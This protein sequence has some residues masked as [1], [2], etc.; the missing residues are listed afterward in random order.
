M[1][2]KC[3][4][5]EALA[6]N[7]IFITVSDVEVK[8]WNYLGKELTELE[9]PSEKRYS[10]LDSTGQFIFLA[11]TQTIISLHLKKENDH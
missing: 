2:F 4:S 8:V 3:L 6:Y 11:G 5:N 7:E 10:C 9:M 1:E